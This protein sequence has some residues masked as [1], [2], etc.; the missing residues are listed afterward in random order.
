MER[1]QV[2]GQRANL[3]GQGDAP[4]SPEEQEALQER[5]ATARKNLG[6]E[7]TDTDYWNPAVNSEE[8][9]GVSDE[10]FDQR[11][12]ERIRQNP[13]VPDEELARQLATELTGGQQAGA[14]G[15]HAQGAAAAG[16]G[17]QPPAGYPPNARQAPD[18]KW[19]VP[20]P[21]SPS[22]WSLFTP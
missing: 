12:A 9:L 15:A 20:D 2:R 11:L 7:W 22:G 5:A 14:A 19:Y 10:E 3:E 1:P 4:P 16:G 13:D 18:G 21:N 17:P 6:P 8:W